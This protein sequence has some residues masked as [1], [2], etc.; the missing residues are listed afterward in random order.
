MIKSQVKVQ[1]AGTGDRTRNVVL[2][3]GTTKKYGF[4]TKADGTH[5]LEAAPGVYTV[6]SKKP[7]ETTSSRRGDVMIMG[8]TC[9]LQ[10][11]N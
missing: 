4:T 8:A 3:Q 6:L 10:I 1:V 9:Q 7:T 2:L 11:A 5:Q